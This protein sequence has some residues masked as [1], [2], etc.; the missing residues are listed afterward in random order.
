MARTL[1]HAVE[2]NEI[3][4]ALR[5]F[6]VSQRDVAAATQV[7]DRAVR[8]W[9]AGGIHDESFDRLQ[10]LRDIVLVLAD[11]LTKRGVGQWLHARNRLLDGACPIDV[12]AEGRVG[13]VRQAAHSFVDGASV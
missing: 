7:S 12:L 1:E 13:E 4:V 10:D 6:G 5:P 9:R 11:S 3:V 2:P 8:A